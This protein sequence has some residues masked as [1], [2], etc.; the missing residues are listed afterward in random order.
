MYKSQPHQIL[1]YITANTILPYSIAFP[2]STEKFRTLSQI[3]NR[4][5]FVLFVCWK[6]FLWAY[7]L[8]L[9]NIRETYNTGFE[10]VIIFG[11]GLS[12]VIFLHWTLVCILFTYFVSWI[13]IFFK[14][15]MKKIGRFIDFLDL[16]QETEIRV[17]RKFSPC[18]F[19]SVWWHYINIFS[20]KL[21]A[22]N[23]I[24]DMKKKNK[25]FNYIINLSNATYSRR[26]YFPL[27]LK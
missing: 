10:H 1:C 19:G 27:P 5:F 6:G 15:K 25:N 18:N 20:L 23:T 14:F 2:F 17:D 4:V 26:K 8:L 7:N 21:Y 9:D 12:K 3:S 22:A 11:V 16:T 24:I 13:C